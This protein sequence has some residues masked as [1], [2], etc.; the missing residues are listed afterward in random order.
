MLSLHPTTGKLMHIRYNPCDRSPLFTLSAEDT[1]LFY[2]YYGKLTQEVQ[3][4][5]N[6]FWVKLKPDMVLFVDNWRVMHGRSA[7]T[8]RRYVS[9]CYLNRDDWISRARDFGLL[10]L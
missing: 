5:D 7:F 9:G 1:R 6:E 4:K 10:S 2:N 3:N 8:G